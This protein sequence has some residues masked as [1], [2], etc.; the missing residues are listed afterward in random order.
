MT[1]SSSRSGNDI[2]LTDNL[3]VKAGVNA[4]DFAAL[5]SIFGAAMEIPDF[6]FDLNGDTI[7]LKGIAPSEQVKAEVEAAAKAAWPN[8]KVVN[9]I[10][11][12]AAPAPQAPAPPP[13]PAPAARR[14]R[15]HDVAGRHHRAC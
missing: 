6:N 11:V 1:A 12:K 8:M 9:N 10:E 13:A 3:N 14:W 4:P 5:G 15:M 7:T 2:E